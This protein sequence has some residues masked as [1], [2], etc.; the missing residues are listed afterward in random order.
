[1]SN[2][3]QPPVEPD[4]PYYPISKRLNYNRSQSL[5]NE[6]ATTQ[7]AHVRVERRPDEYEPAPVTE[8]PFATW[9]PDAEDSQVSGAV[10]RISRLCQCHSSGAIPNCA[11]SANQISAPLAFWPP[12]LPPSI[13][14]GQVLEMEDRVSGLYH[15]TLNSSLA[16]PSPTLQ[17]SAAASIILAGS[18]PPPP[19]TEPQVSAV[20]SSYIPMPAPSI[21]DPPSGMEID[22][23]LLLHQPPVIPLPNDPPHNHQQAQANPS[24]IP[25]PNHQ[26]A[27][28][29]PS[30][31]PSPNH[32]QAPANPS[33]IP[34]PNHY[35]QAQPPPASFLPDYQQPTMP[36]NFQPTIFPQHYSLEEITFLSWHVTTSLGPELQCYNDQLVQTLTGLLN[37]LPGAN[38]S[39]SPINGQMMTWMLQM[40]TMIYPPSKVL[41][42]EFEDRRAVPDV[43]SPI[44]DWMSPLSSSWNT[45]IIRLLT[46]DYLALLN[47]QST[48]NNIIIAEDDMKMEALAVKIKTRLGHSVTAYQALQP[49]SEDSN[50]TPHSKK[51]RIKLS[52][53]AEKTW[54]CQG[55]VIKACLSNKEE[56]SELWKEV[57]HIHEILG[58]DGMSSDKTEVEGTTTWWKAVW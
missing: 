22:P 38:M 55:K 18:L 3:Q 1:M 40:K 57:K 37:T 49:P 20:L 47:D 53:V 27:P 14:S 52:G 51:E 23:S 13:P 7:Y 24:A 41:L 30:A 9:Q 42:K 26:Q 6:P 46:L 2:N 48:Q 56:D 25:S 10:D 44:L 19:A 16:G 54:K 33:G 31:I 50:E 43:A 36:L 58:V 45:E 11:T 8:N 17:T 21:P 4:H 15:A 39:H 5:V 28:A 35:Q 34:S 32:Q 12:P 29:N